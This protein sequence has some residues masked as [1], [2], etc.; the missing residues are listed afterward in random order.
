MNALIGL[1]YLQKLNLWIYVENNLLT[2]KDTIIPYY[3]KIFQFIRLNPIE[4]I[5]ESVS[6]K[7]YE[8]D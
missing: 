2:N 7:N 4:I 1:H 8:S 5:T 3:F 6:I